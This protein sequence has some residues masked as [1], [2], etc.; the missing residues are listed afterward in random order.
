MIGKGK[1]QENGDARPFR[2]YLTPSVLILMEPNKSCWGLL[3]RR[4]CLVPTLTGCLLLILIAIA[5]VVLAVR[6]VHPFLAVTD[7]VPGGVLIVEGWVPDHVLGTVIG[8]YKRNHYTKLFV[9]GIPLEHGAHLSEYTNYA[10][11][12]AVT[13]VKLGMSTNDVQ[14]VP[15]GPTRRDRTYSMALSVKHWLRDH[16]MAPTKV[17]LITGGPHARRS[18][19]MFEKAMGKGVTVG[20]I[21]IPADD[22]EERHWWNTSQGVRT[23]IGEAIAYLYARLLFY[24]PQD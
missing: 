18:R 11:L 19:L 10:Y 4:Q 6:E 15:T 14:P 5:L 23:I 7:S 12:G 22:Y 2:H 21:A 13:L 1:G 16:G 8:E 20:V 9:T 3:R 17:N 24:P